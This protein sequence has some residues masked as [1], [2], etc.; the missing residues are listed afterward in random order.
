MEFSDVYKQCLGKWSPNSQYLAAAAQNRVLVREPSSMRL[1]QVYI[2]LD[3][4]ERIE[5]S[6]NSRFFLT[7]ASRQGVVQIW[8][9]QDS[10]WSCRIDEGLAGVSYARWDNSS[11]RVLVAS[12]FQ[13]YLSIWTLEENA[14]ATQI[15]YPK[16]PNRGLAFSRDGAWLAVL[17]RFD[18]QDRLSVY[19]ANNDMAQ[20]S[21]V[22]L[23]GDSADICW[24]ND[25]T[26]AVWDRPG[27]SPRCLMYSLSGEQLA[28]LGNYPLMRCLV[29]AP[30]AQLLAV[31]CLDGC[32]QLLS[33]AKRSMLATLRHELQVA[34][35]EA[36]DDEVAILEELDSKHLAGAEGIRG[37]QNISA[38]NG[39]LHLEERSSTEPAVDSEGLPRQG[40]VSASW[41]PDERYL[42]TKHESYP[43]VVW[44]WDLGKLILT[45]VLKHQSPV[46]S[47]CWDP[48]TTA[49]ANASRLAI[50]TADPVFFL[51][52]PTT[53]EVTSCPLQL[54]TVR[55]R[56]DGRAVLLQDRD[57][58]CTCEVAPPVYSGL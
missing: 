1:L 49:R 16:Y 24:I 47:F 22:A 27:K 51:W 31:C 38:S 52:T 39:M 30:S 14:T 56:S 32:V 13:L 42:A 48:S 34:F 43:S 2:C 26:I 10:E 44:V 5:W 50:T 33:S 25:A 21:D 57:K 40:I 58:A 11:R 3:K 8:S 23:S 53:F 19:D 15:R 9:V 17:R 35:Q 20:L 37:Y 41:S 55:W 28:D 54:A 45:A 29:A 46:R 18:C 12:N 36:G 6:P 4:V 7:E